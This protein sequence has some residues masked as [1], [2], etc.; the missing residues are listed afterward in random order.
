MTA[1]SRSA[2]HGYCFPDEIIALAVRWYFR[3]RL[4]YVDVAEWLAERGIQVD[5]STIYDWVHT[6][7]PHFIAAARTYRPS[8][9]DR[10]RVVKRISSLAA[11]GAICSAP[12]TSMGTSLMS[13]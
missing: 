4:S 5:P 8:V 3:Y 9:G 2:F 11:A 1:R 6:F 10:W 12:S 7:T 13:T